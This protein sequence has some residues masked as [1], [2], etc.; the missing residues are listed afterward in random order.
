[1]HS[2]FKLYVYILKECFYLQSVKQMKLDG[3]GAQRKTLEW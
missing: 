3:E 2:H 1:M